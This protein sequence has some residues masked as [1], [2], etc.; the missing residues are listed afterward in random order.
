MFS[1]AFT[2]I[3]LIL[4]FTKTS[5]RKPRGGDELGE[6]GGLHLNT[7]YRVMPKNVTLSDEAFWR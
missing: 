6:V 4:T 2:I 3:K 5:L 7:P 1:S